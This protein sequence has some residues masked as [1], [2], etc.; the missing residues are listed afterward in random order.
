M[1]LKPLIYLGLSSLLLTLSCKEAPMKESKKDTTSF[2]VGTY[3]DGESEGIYKYSID[4]EG[5][6]EKIGLM[7]KSDNPSFLAKSNDGNYLL[8]VNEVSND[9]DVGA[10][11][12]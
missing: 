11:I 5:K 7:A 3:T 10:S 2:Y 1:N 4:T 8:A 9:D 12:C 6:L